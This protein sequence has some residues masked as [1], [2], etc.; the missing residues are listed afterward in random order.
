MNRE[1]KFFRYLKENGIYD[2]F[3][4]KINKSLYKGNVVMYFKYTHSINYISALHNFQ[5]FVKPIII[6]R[7]MFLCTKENVEYYPIFNAYYR[8]RVNDFDK[9]E[10]TEITV[11][12]INKL[13]DAYKE[14]IHK[15]RLSALEK[16][17]LKFIAFRNN[18]LFKDKVIK[19][20]DNKR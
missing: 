11:E 2:L 10:L 16:E 6:V 4:D 7:W 14:I 15:K 19:R 18:Q 5:A 13:R 12:E 3:I 17:N 20:N 9:K 1:K 8:D